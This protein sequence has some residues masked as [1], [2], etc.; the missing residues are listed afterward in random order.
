MKFFLSVHYGRDQ[1]VLEDSSNLTKVIR[2]LMH[3]N[4]SF[5]I[6]K[7]RNNLQGR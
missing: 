5:L 4:I 2:D 1:E 6:Y 3:V 7:K